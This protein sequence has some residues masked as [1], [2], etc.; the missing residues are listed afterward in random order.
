MSLELRE[1]SWCSWNRGVTG[2]TGDAV[3]A[4]IRPGG[5]GVTGDAV[6]DE[7]QQQQQQETR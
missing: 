1:D 4:H 6:E 3:S 5:R 2:V 7:Q